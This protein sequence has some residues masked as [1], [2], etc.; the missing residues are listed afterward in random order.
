MFIGLY[1]MKRLIVFAVALLLSVMVLARDAHLKFKG[2]PVDGNYKVFA[3]KLIQ[4]GF[5]QKE[6]TPDGI[7]LTGNFMAE[8]EVIVVVYPDPTSKCVSTVAAMIDAGDNWASI[9]RK[10]YSVVD[11]YK[12]KYGEPKEHVEE[13]D[14]EYSSSDLFRRSALQEGRCNYKSQ[15]EVEGGS[16]TISLLYL[17]FDYYVVCAY[18]DEQNVK[19]LHQTIIDD[20]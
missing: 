9:E 3:E 1:I 14:T 6:V 15:W 11:T 10:Y 7:V 5:K 20:I 18:L 16:I 13:F 8:P 19:A 12:E 4:K 17:S 2:I